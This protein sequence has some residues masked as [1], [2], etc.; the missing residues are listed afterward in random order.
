[1]TSVTSIYFSL[2]GL[3]VD[4][5]STGLDW[6]FVLIYF[7][8]L[9]PMSAL[10]IQELR[11]L[12]SEQKY[13]MAQKW[14]FT[15]SLKSLFKKF[16]LPNPTSVE[17]ASKLGLQWQRA[18]M[19]NFIKYGRK[20]LGTIIQSTLP[21]NSYLQYYPFSWLLTWLTHY[22][23]HVAVTQNSVCLK[24]QTPSALPN[25]FSQLLHLGNNTQIQNY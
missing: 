14:C 12:S 7:M 17:L 5:G 18:W 8:N 10:L 25:N 13:S 19:Y 2:M 20:E 1:M 6:A 15:F 4:C 11:I 21:F 3:Y 23:L 22:G 9:Y 24:S 16:M